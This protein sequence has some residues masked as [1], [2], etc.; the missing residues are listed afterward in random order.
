MAAS[1]FMNGGNSATLTHELLSKLFKGVASISILP[2]EATGVTWD[3]LDFGGADQIFT[4]K[5][6]FT[7]SQDDPTTTNIQIDQK[8]ENIDTTVE[9]GDWTISGNIPTIAE[10]IL[11][12]FY[13]EGALVSSTGIKGQTGTAYKGK[14]FFANPREVYA[15][16]LVENAKQDMAVAFARVKMT[17]GLAQDDTSNPAYLKLNATI[18]AN[19]EATGAQGDWAV[20]K[21]S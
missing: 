16:W 13:D 14:A 20:I 8:D 4:L 1:K 21:K 5:D 7:I 17:V 19:T 10:E 12:I 3:G 11:S 2:Y 18:L 9:Q 15:T 6:T